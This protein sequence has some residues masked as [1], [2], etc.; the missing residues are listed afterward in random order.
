MATSD[1]ANLGH[2]I[3]GERVAGG[4]QP[5][6]N[7]ARVKLK[8]PFCWPTRPRSKRPSP[9]R[10]PRFPPGATHRR[11]SA[12]GMSTLKVLQMQHADELCEMITR[13]Q[14]GKRVQAQ[15]DAKNHAVV[16]PD[17]VVPH[18]VNARMGATF[19]FSGEHC[20]A[21]ALVVA[22]G[23]ETAD[24]VISGLK[25]ELAKMRVVSGLDAH[26][27]MG[28]LVTQAHLEKVKGYVDQGVKEGATLL[29]DD[30]G[31]KLAGHEAVYF[32]GPCLFDHV[33]PGMT[34][35][36]EEISGPVLGVVRV[37]TLEQ[38][39]DLI[40]AHEYGNGTCIFTRNEQAAR[41]FTDNTQVGMLGV[42]VPLPVPM[43]HHSFGGCKRSLF[44]DLHADGLDAV[45]F[46]PSARPSHSAGQRPVG[47][48]ARC[49][50][51]PPSADFLRHY[52]TSDFSTM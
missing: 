18:A 52:T 46:T 27:E 30:R 26:S 45:R 35:Y 34:L 22:V 6:L 38:A 10:R 9:A 31:V 19:G 1:C 20:M 36:Q 29:V 2:H 5:V 3:N 4:G 25:T 50:P 13:E 49:L 11:S 43:A 51:S 42:N 7:P 24:A 40:D 39:P 23:D 47:A 41:Y 14:Y 33:K 48:K 12:R 16:M 44:G 8:A 21:R 32:L 28:P 17:A 37:K 15:G